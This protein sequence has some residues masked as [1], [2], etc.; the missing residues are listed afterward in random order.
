MSAST[1]AAQFGL[2]GE[3]HPA[4][5]EDQSQREAPPLLGRHQRVEVEL[6]LHRVGLGREL[7]ASRRAARRACRPAARGDRTRPTARRCRSCGPRPGA[8][9]GPRAPWAPRRR[10]R[11]RAGAPC[12][13]GSSSSTGRSR[14][15]GRALDLVGVGV[16]EV[17]RRR[18]LG[19]QRR[20]D[21][22]DVLVGGLRGEDRRGEQLDTRRRGPAR[23]PRPDTRRARRAIDLGRACFGP[24][25]GPRRVTLSRAGLPAALGLELDDVE[26]R[27][28]GSATTANRPGSMSIGRHHDAPPSSFTRR[29]RRRRRRRR[30]TR[31]RTVAPRPGS[32]AASASSRRSTARRPATRCTR[33]AL[34]VGVGAPAEHGAV[35]RLRRVDVGGHQLVPRPSAGLV[36]RAR[37][38][39]ARRL[40]HRERRA[41]GST[42]TAMRPASST[43]IGG[44]RTCPPF[45]VTFAARVVGAVDGHVGRPHR[46]PG[47]LLRPETGDRPS[48]DHGTRG[49]RPP[50]RD[51]R[52]TPIRTAPSR[53]PRPCRRRACRGRPRTGFRARTGHLHGCLRSSAVAGA[54]P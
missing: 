47:A 15:S 51:P 38:R 10:T 21:L 52:D 18:V 46:R 3:A 34:A 54:R 31:P 49:S 13:A 2:R 1:Q 45:A 20:R 5:V 48:A 9:R 29:R 39:C 28:R 37:H 23:T 22:V 30:S 6:R 4:A 25:A 40:P 42:N 17:A 36:R 44:T 33:P 41:D 27:T 11:R 43:S 16:R 7:Q 35:E 26:R 12:R 24:G 8:S 19:E 14:S 32:S 53:T 50:L